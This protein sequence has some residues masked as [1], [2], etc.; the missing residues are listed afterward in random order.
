MR[1]N[2]SRKVLFITF[3]SLISAP[4]AFAGFQII[5]DDK[6][7]TTHSLPVVR[8][9]NPQ[10]EFQAKI[11]Q[12]QGELARVQRELDLARQDAA[13]TRKALIVAN[14]Q[15][16]MIQTKL[17]QISVTFPLGNS[18][19]VPHPDAA[20]KIIAY[21]KEANSINVRGY[22][23]SI[24]STSTNRRIA[25]QRANAAKSYL[26]AQG[27]ADAKISVTAELGKYVASNATEGGRAA[28]RRVEVEFLR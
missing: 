1:I 25:L 26:L 15:L 8:G 23:D 24:G 12:L 10:A 22:T 2:T 27:I 4:V 18:E 3:A 20:E 28:N 6:T 11:A 14:A 16:D 21:A 19:F 9:P 13:Q 5:D 17:K 7:L